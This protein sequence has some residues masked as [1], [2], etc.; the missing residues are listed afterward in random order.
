MTPTVKAKIREARE[1]CALMSDGEGND[2]AVYQNMAGQ[3]RKL[4]D[5]ALLDAE[6]PREGWPTLVEAESGYSA[7]TEQFVS[8]YK[9]WMACARWYDLRL[10]S[11]LQPPAPVEGD[12][13]KQQAVLNGL[14][15][16][17]PGMRTMEDQQVVPKD[18]WPTREEFMAAFKAEFPLYTR[19]HTGLWAYDFL[20]KRRGG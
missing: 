15:L 10:K 14:L 19:D 4:L 9:S 16:P 3:A 1:L 7:C 2:P 6:P 13:A 12:I 20:T 8:C 5:A 18:E 17:Q 11:R